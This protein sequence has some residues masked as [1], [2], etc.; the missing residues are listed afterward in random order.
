MFERD[1][2][3]DRASGANRPQQK[4]RKMRVI[5]GLSVGFALAA[6]LRTAN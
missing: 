2:W 6:R 4:R 3:A 5:A 1:P